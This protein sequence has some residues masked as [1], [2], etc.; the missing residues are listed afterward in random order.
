MWR[1][2]RTPLKTLARAMGRVPLTLVFLAVMLA[3]NGLA[4]T[5][6]GPIDPEVLIA[7]G[8][9]VDALQGG[10]LLRFVT[11][12]FLSH[13][14]AMLL[15]QLAFAALVIGAVEWVWGSLAAAVLFFGID[16]VST[17][18][19]LTAVALIPSLDTLTGVTDVGMSMGGFGLIGVLAGA[20]RWRGFWLVAVLC[21]VAA[22]YAVAPDPLADGGHVIALMIGFCTGFYRT[23]ISGLAIDPPVV[24]QMPLPGQA[25]GHAA[26]RRSEKSADRRQQ[27][28]QR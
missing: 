23:H 28:G 7:R 26:G 8:I 6:S 11:A 25:G 24:Q 17:V 27:D 10:D 9:G 21:L 18:I 16:V 5:F 22:K 2:D 3:A 15:R 4:G 14:L 13:D 19:L 12:I 20:V 1:P